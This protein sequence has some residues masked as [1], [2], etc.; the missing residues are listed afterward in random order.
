MSLA[1]WSLALLHGFFVL[2]IAGLTRSKTAV[3]F[4]AIVAAAVGLLVGNPVYI[5]LD[6]LCVAAATYYC[7]TDLAKGQQS[8]PQ[9]IAAA[10]EK[11]RLE[12]IKAAEAAAKRDKAIADLL[13][14][15]VGIVAVGG[16]L[17][18]KFWEPSVPRHDPPS[19]AT[20]P[21]PQQAVAQP[22]R[23]EV[24]PQNTPRADS[25]KQSV[26]TQRAAKKTT[27]IK[28]H[29]VEKCLEIPNEQAM[30]R[31]LESAQ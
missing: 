22:A 3:A 8:S 24:K 20:Q 16:F 25:K 6:L 10:Q 23:A 9:E 26:N 12:R 4:A 17:L 13:Q 30:V 11:A 29:P 1:V 5:V 18:W 28:K 31:C 15:A 7:W 14:G 27:P 21:H 2:I 19:A